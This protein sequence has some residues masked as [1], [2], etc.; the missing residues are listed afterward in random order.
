MRTTWLCLLMMS[1][2]ACLRAVETVDA[3][4]PCTVGFECCSTTMTCR[5]ANQCPTG[6]LDSGPGPHSDADGGID[7]GANPLVEV[8][9]L[10]LMTDGQAPS[11]VLLRNL[12]RPVKLEVVG[13]TAYVLARFSRSCNVTF[14]TDWPWALSRLDLTGGQWRLAWTSLLPLGLTA[15]AM[16]AGPEGVTIAGEGQPAGFPNRGGADAWVFRWRP[17]GTQAWTSQLGSLLEEGARSLLVRDDGRVQVA[18]FTSGSLMGQPGAGG[19]DVFAA[20]LRNDGSVEWIQ[21]FGSTDGDGL[22]DLTP[23]PNGDLIVSGSTPG[24]VEPGASARPADLFLR[25]INAVGTTVWTRQFPLTCTRGD[26]ERWGADLVFVNTVPRFSDQTSSLARITG[27]GVLA[28]SADAGLMDESVVEVVAVDADRVALRGLRRTA[29]ISARALQHALF[30]QVWSADGGSTNVSST[31]GGWPRQSTL[32]FGP[33]VGHRS[34]G[35]W[36]V[37]GA[38]NVPRD[39]VTFEETGSTGRVAAADWKF[40]GPSWAPL[41]DPDAVVAQPLAMKVRETVVF[42]AGVAVATGCEAY[43]GWVWLA[44]SE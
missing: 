40:T 35:R 8:I 14:S 28:W 16:V 5:P 22:V 19:I 4:C 32:L 37:A 44:R 23:M 43:S 25:R 26:L 29:D 6:D 9:P 27:D 13:D 12:T 30:E 15:R 38:G 41:N 20:Q 3:P 10:S 33:Q 2:L 34:N 24:V 39:I 31:S 36:V 1:E 18:G 17:D 7:A 42:S 11:V 21:V